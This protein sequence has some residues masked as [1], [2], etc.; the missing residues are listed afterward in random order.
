MTAS[1]PD[2]NQLAR[3]EHA[4]S[5]F[6]LSA[7][8]CWLPAHNGKQAWVTHAPFAFWLMDV[9]RP[10]SIVELGTHYGFSCFAFAEAVRR[11]GLDCRISA[12][13]NW[14]GDDQGG[15][16]TRMSSRTTRA[17]TAP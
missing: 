14:E 17:G 2:H 15:L 7:S 16:A 5:T 11:L 12:L 8:S 6:W 4:R 3:A 1:D 10:H 13:D 9:L